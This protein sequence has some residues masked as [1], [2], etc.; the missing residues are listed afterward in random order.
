M[1]AL[2]HFLLGNHSAEQTV[3]KNTVWLTVSQF[4]ARLIR[5]AFMVY[6]ARL[7]GAEGYGILSYALSIAALLS[8]VT[9]LGIG[10]VITREGSKDTAHQ[11]RYLATGAVAKFGLVAIASIGLVIWFI[12]GA[13]HEAL[14]PLVIAIIAFDGIRDL[15][16]ALFRAQER[17]EVEAVI[18]LITN[19]GIAGITL[20]VA[21]TTT[22]LTWILGGYAAGCLLGALAAL[23]P[24]R[25]SLRSAARTYDRTLLCDLLR[26]SWTF[27]IIGLVGSIMLNTDAIMLAWFRP[28][29]EVGYYAAAQRIVQLL[30]VLPLPIVSALFP[31]VARLT[32]ENEKF[33]SLIET[34]SRILLVLGVGSALALLTA[35]GATIRLLYGSDFM[36]AASSLAIMSLTLIPAFV[37]SSLTNALFAL[38]K[39]RALISYASIAI[40]ANVG[41]NLLFI[42]TFG[43]PGSALATLITQT[44]LLGYLT[45]TLKKAAGVTVVR[46]I[47]EIAVG[48]C[49]ALAV[50]FIGLIVG[51]NGIIT[52]C[53]AGIVYLLL[54]RWLGDESI[55]TLETRVRGILTS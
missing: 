48:V 13:P 30:Y 6:L 33:K 14:L 35:S 52:G 50:A 21:L 3:A 5:A 47:A 4:A 43:G 38:K 10:G 45:L 31:V 29:A 28:E 11:W 7:V 51:I 44:V 8:S 27:G 15:A 37:A 17:M 49:G 36:P 25:A 9:D 16:T 46:D 55:E 26:S 53:A 41:L 2:R 34:S 20:L 1:N 12:V 32:L 23:W 22:N 40:I 39:E 24:L 42:P 19:I 18:Q 54:L